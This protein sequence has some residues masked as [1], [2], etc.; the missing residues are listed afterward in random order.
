MKAQPFKEQR[1]A[2]QGPARFVLT[3][4]LCILGTACDTKQQDQKANEKPPRLWDGAAQL[5]THRTG[6]KPLDATKLDLSRYPP[7]SKPANLRVPVDWK[8]DPHGDRS[9]RARLHGWQW[10]WPL[11]VDHHKNRNKRS[12]VTALTIAEDW[13]RQNPLGKRDLSE[14]AWGDTQ[15]GFRAEALGYLVRA[16]TEGNL[17]DDASQRLLLESAIQHGER[18]A[19]DKYYTERHNHGL[20]QDYSV[21]PLGTMNRRGGGACCAGNCERPMVME[22]TRFLRIECEQQ[23]PTKSPAR[24]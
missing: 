9:W 12:F 6:V 8:Q 3:L 24:A 21:E 2:T 15:V 19:D 16:G 18:L 10:I 1:R 23:A 4:L 20:F 7:K 11:L 5:L 14:F 17:L 22:L 13:L